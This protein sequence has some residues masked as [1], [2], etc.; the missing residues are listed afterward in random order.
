MIRVLFVCHGN[1]CRSPMAE[2]LFNQA[3][4]RQDEASYLDQATKLLHRLSDRGIIP[5]HTK[6]EVAIEERSVRA[7]KPGSDQT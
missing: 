4:T 2:Y 1:I 7:L 5:P 6:V 3:A